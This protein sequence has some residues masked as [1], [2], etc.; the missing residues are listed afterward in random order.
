MATGPNR[1]CQ[2]QFSGNSNH[3]AG[4]QGFRTHRGLHYEKTAGRGRDNVLHLSL[5]LSLSSSGVNTLSGSFPKSHSSQYSEFGATHTPLS[6]DQSPDSGLVSTP[7]SGSHALCLTHT[8]N[9]PVS[10]HCCCHSCSLSSLHSCR[11]DSF[12][13]LHLS[14]VLPLF[15]HFSRHP[16]SNLSSLSWTWYSHSPALPSGHWPLA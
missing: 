4:G 12:I 5:S 14:R 11:S 10:A 9:N 1:H 15:F 3:S 13:S 6:V 16:P 8:H 7:V 2:A